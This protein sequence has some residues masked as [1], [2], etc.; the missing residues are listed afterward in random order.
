[1]Q[2]NSDVKKAY[3]ND[4]K[5]ALDHYLAFGIKEGRRS[6]IE[7]YSQYYKDKNSDLKKFNNTELTKHFLTFGIHEWR[8][9]SPDFNVKKYRD[10]Y[11]DLRKAFGNDCKAYYKHYMIFGQAEK[12]IA[13]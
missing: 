13:L 5:K 8:E 6:A 12:R 4:Y 3:G 9:T 7:Y 10:R 1:M 11:A 2:I